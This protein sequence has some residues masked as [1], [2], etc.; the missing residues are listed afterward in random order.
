MTKLITITTIHVIAPNASGL[1]PTL[2]N[3]PIS[4][5]IPIPPKAVLIKNV[6]KV[7]I[8]DV[9]YSGIGIILATILA[10]KNTI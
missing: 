4:T 6:D 2:K 8:Y 5:V 10:M 3:L 7:L 9:I 1:I